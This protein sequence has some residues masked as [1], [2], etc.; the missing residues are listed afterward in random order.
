MVAVVASFPQQPAEVA[1]VVGN[2]L[3]ASLPRHERQEMADRLELVT[4][5]ADQ[6]LYGPDAVRQHPVFSGG[7]SV[8]GGADG[9]LVGD[10]HRGGR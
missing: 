7:L 4:L 8:G 10:R 2:Q 6:V 5:Q 1:A 3:L 9:G